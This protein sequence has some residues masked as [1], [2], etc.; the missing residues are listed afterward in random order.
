MSESTIKQKV[1]ESIDRLPEDV[2]MEEIVERIQFIQKIEIGL[3]QAEK[4]ELISHEEVLKKI[5][6][7]GTLKI[8]SIFLPLANSSTNLSRYRVCLVSGVSISSIR[9]PQITPVIR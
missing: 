6:S 5:Y 7:F 1:L 4:G 8:F 3:E 9:Y 2:S